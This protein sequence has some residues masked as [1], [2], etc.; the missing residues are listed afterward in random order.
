MTTSLLEFPVSSF[1][2]PRLTE[3]DLV[4]LWEGQRFPPQALRTT[5]GMP[6]RA[7]YRGRRNG[8]A[9]P[10]FRDAIIASPDGLLQGDI[11]LHVRSSDYRRHGHHLDP[12]YDGLALHLVFH[13]DGEGDTELAC[14]RRVPVVALADWASRR[15]REIRRWL[16]RPVTWEEPCRSAV[17]RLGAKPAG[18]ALERLGDMRFRA[19]TASYAQRFRLA[20][21]DQALWEGILE[22]LGYGGG[23]ELMRSL[24]A[25][26]PWETV[27]SKMTGARPSRRS[28]LAEAM[29]REGVADAGAE[30]LARGRPG[31]TL[32][33]RLRGAAALA[34]RF[35]ARGPWE[36]LRGPVE[37]GRM[38][39]LLDLLTV[40]GAIGRSRAIETAVNAVLP[41]A[42][43]AGLGAQAETLYARLPLPARYGN[44]SHIHN[45]LGDA[46]PVN[47][48]RQ[49]GMLYLLREYCSQGGC[50]RCPLS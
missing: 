40:A 23:R 27:A 39:A 41:C 2:A 22:S 31:N 48:R 9:G 44:V 15:A 46:V 32:D 5:A 28:A 25:R 10:D 50:G 7:V 36:S 17:T 13:Y 4:H 35:L 43:A 45:A 26:A 49:Q 24:A 3:A 8:G 6:L 38:G 19:R 29:L 30:G 21:M 14:G 34:G 20:G 18:A 33:V 1:D 16:E 47:A 12:A 37:D 42:A 11:E